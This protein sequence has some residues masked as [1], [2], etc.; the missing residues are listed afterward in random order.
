MTRRMADAFCGLLKR[1]GPSEWI[2]SIRYGRG[3]VSS[4]SCLDCDISSCDASGY[5]L[6]VFS[7][8]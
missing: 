6:D 2:L 3:I 5:L 7:A 4:S 8:S 1:L